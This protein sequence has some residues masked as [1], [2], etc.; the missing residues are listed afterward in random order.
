MSRAV[1]LP[2]WNAYAFFVTYANVDTWQPA[3][4][5]APRSDNELDR[6]IVS[7]LNH[8]IAQVNT[9]M[10]R[11]NLYRVVPLLVDFID[12]L[13]NWYIRRSRRRFWKSENDADK[14]GAYGTLYHV[15][16]EFATVMAP[17]LPFLT[18]AIYRNLGRRPG[19]PASVHLCPFPQADPERM[20]P[21][22]ETKMRLVRQA[23]SMGRALR[24]RFCIK[25]RQPLG[26][27]TVVVRNPERRALLAEMSSLIA[28]ELNV[29]TVL[30]GDNEDSL[31]SISAKPNYRKLGR[32]YGPAMKEAAAEIEALGPADIRA[33]EAGESRRIR[34][35]TI[36]F[37]DIELRRERHEGIE[38]ETEGEITVALS[39]EI[40]DELRAEGHA[41]EL[42]NRVQN[43]RKSRGL[44]VTDRILLF[45]A[46]DE[47]LKHA[48]EA[49]QDY[50][51]TETLADELRWQAA[52]EA[53]SVD[54][55]GMAARI[56]LEKR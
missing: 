4:S 18:E 51:R 46:C 36:G 53:E 8:T 29:K 49:H 13:T 34:G 10:E 20:D 26:E 11:Y 37:D 41:R 42:V 39:T 45:C 44:E 52:A 2:F 35:H 12:N 9:E 28:E 19:A 32:I 24:S 43:L 47:E 7:L 21:A 30:F 22:L 56:T 33:L 6:W 5:E 48:L 14:T 16:V 15:L 54:I 23:V 55:N 27:M 50:I 1:L 17:F 25:T 3:E 40:T 31:V 38:V